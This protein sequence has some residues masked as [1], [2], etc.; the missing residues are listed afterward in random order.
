[1]LELLN[2]MQKTVVFF[3]PTLEVGG[4]EKNVVNILAGLNKE[5]YAI[6]LLVCKKRG[7]FLRDI[8]VSIPVF[9]LR[10]LNSLRVFWGVLAFLRSHKPDIFV[11]NLSRFNVIN[12]LARLISGG[13]SKMIV[14]EHTQASLLPFTAKSLLHRLGARFIFPVLAGI[15]YK[16]AVRVI[17]VSHAVKEDLSALFKGAVPV[18]VIYNPVVSKDMLSLAK[19]AAGHPWFNDKSIPVVLS[20]G[21][22]VK[23]KNHG[24]LLKAFALVLEHEKAN[25]VILGQGP[26]RRDLE[27]LS[28]AFGIQHHVALLGFEPN[29][30]K[31]MARADVFVSSSAREGFGNAIVEAMALALPVV[32][33]DC[34]GPVE[35]IQDA[36]VLVPNENPRLLADAIIKVLDD[37]N[38]GGKLRQK[39]LERANDFLIET[40]VKNYEKIF[41]T[42]LYG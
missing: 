36:G 34:S 32:S 23:A 17:A 11:S 21:R 16:N 41:D 27:A 33:T 5:K 7:E 8:P 40:S 37:K 2:N 18:Q 15:L 31:Y 3:I 38:L 22:L 12:L 14:V 39:G 24:L 9:E 35:I 6:T 1:M 10:S 19:E 4:A 20:V 30:F 25:L 13:K 42:L 29:P 28:S 26:E